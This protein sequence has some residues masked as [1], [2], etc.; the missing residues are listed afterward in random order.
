MSDELQAKVLA[1]RYVADQ[2]RRLEL[3]PLDEHGFDQ[4]MVREL[5]LAHNGNVTRV[6]GALGV[7]PERLRAYVRAMPSLGRAIDEAMDQRVDQ[8]IDVLFDALKDEASF[9]N[10]YYAAKEFL[11]S[12]FGRKRGFGPRET[13]TSLEVKTSDRATSITIKW[14]DPPKEG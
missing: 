6:A 12:E 1:S 13:A 4:D 11:R 9:Q 10:R 2:E 5:L 3:V 14:L 7:K 8:A